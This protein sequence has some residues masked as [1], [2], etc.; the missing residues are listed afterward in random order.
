[1]REPAAVRRARLASE[2]LPTVD[3][4]LGYASRQTFRARHEEQG[5]WVEQDERKIRAS[6]LRDLG[7]EFVPWAWVVEGR[8]DASSRPS[9]DEERQPLVLRNERDGRTVTLRVER[10]VARPGVRRAA[11]SMDTQVLSLAVPP[12]AWRF[13]DAQ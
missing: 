7:D 8:C 11:G 6:P 12:P 9:A 5:I 2:G 1:M 13:E 3:Q 10:V 4:R